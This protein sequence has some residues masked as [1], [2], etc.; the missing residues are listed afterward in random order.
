VTEIENA[1]R[2]NTITEAFG[3]GTAAVVAPVAT[4][5]INGIDHHLPAYNDKAIMFQ[6]KN[7]M[8]AIRT[9]QDVDKHGWNFLF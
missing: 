6:L 9:G 8:E 4:I 3:A 1:F 2:H 7:K 5:H